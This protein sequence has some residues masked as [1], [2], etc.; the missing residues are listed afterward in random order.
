MLAS[1][2]DSGAFNVQN[3]AAISNFLLVMGLCKRQQPLYFVGY[4]M[5]PSVPQNIQRRKI[6]KSANAEL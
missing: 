1:S 2:I 3:L 5:T 4:F 6:G